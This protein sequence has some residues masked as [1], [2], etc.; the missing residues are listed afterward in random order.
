MNQKKLTTFNLTERVEKFKQQASK[1]IEITSVDDWDGRILLQKEQE[2]RDVALSLAGECIA[3]LLHQLS[4]LPDAQKTAKEKTKHW[5][6]PQ[7]VGNGKTWRMLTTMGNVTVK[8]HLPYVVERNQKST[9]K[10]KRKQQGFCPFL[11]WLGIEEGVTPLVWSTIAKISTISH[12]FA[13][14]KVMLKEWGIDI[15]ERRIERLTYA[16]GQLGLSLR[17]LKMF[18]LNQGKIAQ[19]NVLEGKRVVISVDGGRTRIRINQ[20]GR[21]NSKT[22]RHRYRGEW[23]EPKLLTIYTVDEKGKKVKTLGIPITNDGTYSNYQEFLKLLEM[24]LVSLGINRAK[25]VLLIADGAGWIWKHIPPLLSKLNC[26]VNAHQLLDFYHGCEHLK[27]FADHAFTENDKSHQWWQKAKKQLKNG[28]ISSLLSQM[29]MIAESH[30][31]ETQKVLVQ[32]INYFQKH[33]EQGRLNY[34]QVAANKLPI[35]SG[36]IESLVRQVVNLRLKGNGKFWLKNHAEIIL[37]CRCQWVGG[38]WQDFC[39][40]I[41]TAFLKT[42][43]SG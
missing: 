18:E 12:S 26:P 9:E 8:L 29:R 30:R 14:A 34:A 35:G 25:E 10:N 40:S 23:I 43:D 28:E 16:F 32:E 36:A 6:L 27:L 2:I 19:R 4:E 41:L 15:S 33:H 1:I 11:R 20:P 24:H 22:R 13:T 5:C 42:I 21:K 39:D 37:H 31:D 17:K 3:L 7:S 38:N